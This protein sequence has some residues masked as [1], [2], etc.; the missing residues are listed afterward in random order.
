MTKG[1]RKN[2][3]K[4][5]KESEDEVLEYSEVNEVET[6]HPHVLPDNAS[7]SLC[8][9]SM[10]GQHESSHYDVAA[11]TGENHH[12]SDKGDNLA[13]PGTVAAAALMEETCVGSS[14]LAS[15]GEQQD[16]DIMI[17][18][19][20]V[21][22]GELETVVSAASETGL[23]PQH[24]IQ[25]VNSTNSNI[26]VGDV[27]TEC[28][29]LEVSSVT[30]AAVE[31]DK[32][33]GSKCN[34]LLVTPEADDNS[35]SLDVVGHVENGCYSCNS[36]NDDW[37]VYW[38]SFYSR[39]YFFNSKTSVSSWD[40]PPGMEHLLSVDFRSKPDEQSALVVDSFACGESIDICLSENN[41]ESLNNSFD[42]GRIADLALDTLAMECVATDSVM[43]N[44]D[45]YLDH[46]G[47]DRCCSDLLCSLSNTHEPCSR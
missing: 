22:N 33:C 36:N 3:S 43:P 28:D 12:P 7:Y 34:K 40:P 17:C 8:R 29:C 21:S 30:N 20:I 27:T 13:C 31:D 9:I 18:G 32:S 2:V 10:L 11:D 16:S 44:L 42:D 35:S 26:V 41:A 4:K 47:V 45:N 14:H 39:N 24:R 5:S 19:A 6:V 23:L 38:D 46:L 1:K 37:E 25:D 15:N